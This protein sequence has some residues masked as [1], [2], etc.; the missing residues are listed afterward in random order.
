[1]KRPYDLLVLENRVSNFQL[2]Q[3]Y[4]IAK[5][6]IGGLADYSQSSRPLIAIL[7]NAYLIGLEDGAGLG[8]IIVSEEYIGNYQI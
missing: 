4:S 2:H 7:A 1:M 5:T 3:V 6:R 8:D